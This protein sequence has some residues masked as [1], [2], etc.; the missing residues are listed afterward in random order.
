MPRFLVASI[1]VLAL[2]AGSLCSPALAAPAKKKPVR[3]APAR[4]AASNLPLGDRD[5]ARELERVL[6]AKNAPADSESVLVAV[7]AAYAKMDFRPAWTS[8]GTLRSAADELIAVLTS[9][10]RYGLVAADYPVDALRE[11]AER[12]RSAAPGDTAR[13]P[14]ALARWDLLASE[15]FVRFVTQVS[16]GRARPR[17]LYTEWYS[18]SRRVDAA[19]LLVRSV[20]EGNVRE[21]ATSIEPPHPGYRNLKN[22]YARYLEVAAKGGWGQVAYGDSLKRNQKDDRVEPLRKRLVASGDLSARKAKGKKF[23][24]SVR[25]AIQRFQRR[26]GIAASGVT[27]SETVDLMNVPVEERLREMQLNLERWRWLPDDFGPFYLSVNIPEFTLRVMDQG[28]M[29]DSMRVIVGRYYH[30][31]PVFYDSITTIVL[32]PDWAVPA[33]I[34]REELL[35]LVQRDSS[36]FGRQNIR[37]YRNV[38]GKLREIPADTV[39]WGEVTKTEFPYTLRQDPG[40]GNPLGR[41]KFLLPNPYDIYLHDTPS[42]ELFAQTR[43][44]FS[45]GCVRLSRPFDLAH[46]LLDPASWPQARIDTMIASGRSDT[47]SVDP[48]VPVFITYWTAWVDEAGEV[49]FRDDVYRIDFRQDWA[50]KQRDKK[51]GLQVS[52]ETQAP[53]QR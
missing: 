42:T 30:P 23:D 5:V 10:D 49:Q 38:G 12:I 41:I 53:G 21:L 39:H 52:A 2:I 33:A 3:K 47:L 9:A 35:P 48:P 18:P 4:A 8:E 36:Y 20:G 17:E 11:G 40:P 29:A 14:E 13:S 28:H 45:Y 19:A 32:N 50:W 22:A 44:D 25:E 51:A 31:T 16:G 37:V 46:D 26:H 1:L 43:R 15:S 7:R 24:D 6:T 34:A 27:D